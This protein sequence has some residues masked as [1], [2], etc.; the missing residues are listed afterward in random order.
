MQIK[1]LG[2]GCSKCQY[3][4][5][6][7][8]E[9]AAEVGVGAEF[10]HVRDMNEILAYAILGTPALV[11]DEVVKCSGRLPRR[12]DVVAWLREAAARG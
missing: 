5:R 3:L 1:I 8:R 10:I 9:A 2:T 6:M 4:E 11:V 7:A 12:E